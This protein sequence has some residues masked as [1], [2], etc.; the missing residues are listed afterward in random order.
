MIKYNVPT[1][2]TLCFGTAIK[3]KA[4]VKVVDIT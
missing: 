1:I 2:S 4:L 3:N